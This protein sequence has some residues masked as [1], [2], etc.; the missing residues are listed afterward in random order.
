MT[1][2]EKVIQ[3]NAISSAYDQCSAW[4]MLSFVNHFIPYLYLFSLLYFLLCLVLY[5]AIKGNLY[6]NI[7][8]WLN[9]A[10]LLVLFV[11]IFVQ[12]HL[13]TDN[14]D[15]LE[16][17]SFNTIIGIE[18]TGLALFTFGSHLIYLIKK[19]YLQK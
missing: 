2:A 5:P 15:Y 1:C 9:I 8:C 12:I 4:S 16:T 18:M 7:F 10:L 19:Y 13:L 3:N 6:K 11:Y 17:R 14:F